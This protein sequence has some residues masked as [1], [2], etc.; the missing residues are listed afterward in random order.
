M[1][2]GDW[3]EVPQ[4][5][6]EKIKKI[7][8]DKF[9]PAVLE[10]L[11]KKNELKHSYKDVEFS[12]IW[13]LGASFADIFDKEHRYYLSQVSHITWLPYDNYYKK[14]AKKLLGCAVKICNIIGQSGLGDEFRKLVQECFIPDDEPDLNHPFYL[15][16]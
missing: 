11:T 12:Q 16:A 3:D 13:F 14:E 10:F 2:N 6:Q 4:D 5:I 9:I 15:F 1:S 8:E 7:A